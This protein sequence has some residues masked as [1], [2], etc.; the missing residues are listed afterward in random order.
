MFPTPKKHSM[1]LCCRESQWHIPTTDDSSVQSLIKP[2][3][4]TELTRIFSLHMLIPRRKRIKLYRS[5]TTISLYSFAATPSYPIISSQS[6]IYLANIL[7]LELCFMELSATFWRVSSFLHYPMS[8][9]P[10]FAPPTTSTTTMNQHLPSASPQ[11]SAYHLSYFNPA[12]Q[13]IQKTQLM[14]SKMFIFSPFGSKT[15]GFI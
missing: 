2:G 14:M 5:I 1:T 3:K 13:R 10:I 4:N 9:K 12:S 15:S 7:Q 8:N 11:P 6:S